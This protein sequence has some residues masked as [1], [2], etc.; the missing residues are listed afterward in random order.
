[1]NRTLFIALRTTLVTLVLTGLCY[2]LAVTGLSQLLFSAKANGSLVEDGRGHAVGS[3]LI[4]QGFS[5]PGYLQPRPS[6]AGDKGYDAMASGGSNFG[7]TSKK[8]QDR[9]NQDAAR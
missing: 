5:N 9:V 7:V 8:L 6:A 1:M 2:P 3:E 4:G